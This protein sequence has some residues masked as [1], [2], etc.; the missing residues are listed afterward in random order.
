MAHDKHGHFGVTFLRPAYEEL[1]WIE[2]LQKNSTH[3]NELLVLIAK[4]DI[5][6]SLSA[7]NN[8]A[9]P[10][11]MK[12][13]GF[14]E[15]FVAETIASDEKIRRRIKE[16]GKTLQWPNKPRSLLPN[17]YWLSTKVNR[18]HDYKFL[19]HATSR[20]VHFTSG[21]L[22]RRVWVQEGKVDIG[23]ST[24]SDYWTAFAL[25]WGFHIYLDL[26]IA[27]RDE[28]RDAHL[29]A[30]KLEELAP[31]LTKFAKVPIITPQELVWP[32]HKS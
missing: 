31:L 12:I 14:T 28:F 21:E 18:E 11:G 25:Y 26:L 3:A 32:D 17:M 6:D 19:Y 5:I 9:R 10:E 7:Q 15:S 29:D 4:H 20:F 13:I 22:F 8:Y 2:Y 1:V 30:S 27:C 23:S 16:I 24:F